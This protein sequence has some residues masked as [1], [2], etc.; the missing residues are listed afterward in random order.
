VNERLLALKKIN[1]I[2]LQARRETPIFDIEGQLA[3]S[4]AWF[5]AA[6]RPQEVLAALPKGAAAIGALDLRT[7][8]DA[9]LSVLKLIPGIA[10]FVAFIEL[11]F[12]LIWPPAVAAA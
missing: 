3:L 7:W 6:L 4:R 1:E 8:I 5:Y 11:I 12:D 9:I 2:F 10:P